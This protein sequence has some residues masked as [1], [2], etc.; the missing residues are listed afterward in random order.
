MSDVEPSVPLIAYLF[1]DRL[2]PPRRNSHGTHVPCSTQCVHTQSLAVLLF[3]AA[4]WSL[5]EQTLIGL[6]IVEHPS[7]RWPLHHHDVELKTLDRATRPGLEGAVMDNLEDE[8]TLCDVVCRW[9]SKHSNNP[10][11]DVIEEETAEAL[12]AGYLKPASEN[13]GVLARLIG[14]GNELESDC[15]RIAG[16][17]RE[18]SRFHE[19]WTDFQ[20]DEAPIYEHLTAACK[21]AL[22]TC[23]ELW[24]P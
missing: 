24:Y 15:S 10:W 22:L 8:T 9:S 18:F 21:K 13:T 4:F 12:A 3:S 2:L 1:A 19:S 7:R 5:R 16:L 14:H 6:N 20:E 11:H 23:T 17:E